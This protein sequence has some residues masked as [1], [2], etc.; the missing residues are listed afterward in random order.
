MRSVPQDVE[1]RKR[2][3]KNQVATYNGVG[4]NKEAAQTPKRVAKEPTGEHNNSTPQRG[5]TLRDNLL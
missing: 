4:Y 3:R 1:Y 2:Q 5:G